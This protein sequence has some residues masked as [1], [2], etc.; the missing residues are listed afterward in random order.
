MLRRGARAFTLLEMLVV[1]AIMMVLM[2]LLFPVAMAAYESANRTACMSN[3]QLIS[4][5]V[6]MYRQDYLVY[7]A[8]PN[9]IGLH[10]IPQGGVTGLA[11]ASADMVP[12]NFWCNRDAYPEQLPP[13]LYSKVGADGRM[14][15]DDATRAANGLERDVT[16]STYQAFYNYY[17]YVTDNDGLPF[18]VT[19]LEAFRYFFGDPSEVSIG[20]ADPDWDLDLVV[21]KPKKGDIPEFVPRGLTQAL[22]NTWAP[23]ETIITYC[24]HHPSG[25]P[26]VLPAVNILGE[27]ELLRPIRPT[28][29]VTL[30]A[31]ADPQT[32]SSYTSVNESSAVLRKPVISVGGNDVYYTRWKPPI[33][34]RINRG[35]YRVRRDNGVF[36]V[37]ED[38]KYISD[39]PR[40]PLNM[41]V[42]ETYY[43]RFVA[44]PGANG[45]LY[46]SSNFY[47]WYDTGISLN[48]GDMVMVVATAKWNFQNR[49][50]NYW[51][52]T[53][54]GWANASTEY[55]PY[56]DDTNHLWFT[57][58]GNPVELSYTDMRPE[59][60]LPNHP[61]CLLVGFVGDPITDFTGGAV[62]DDGNPATNTPSPRL[63]N[64]FPIGSRGSFLAARAGTLKVSSNDI[65]GASANDDNDGWCELWVAVYRHNSK[66]L[67][68]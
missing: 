38:S 30:P 21:R 61:H 23:K 9:Y 26:S 50:K 4:Q 40:A 65:R 32:S 7:P 55:E 12:R 62:D 34:W 44:K 42:V 56:F 51:L 31:T 6:E 28:A 19:T 18:P 29:P 16:N 24:P 20:M 66:V 68:Q 60:L 5:R 49:N 36:Q 1:V 53:S 37:V 41:P 39:A 64:Y 43:R 27:A 58:E 33:D 22:W 46:D 25:K 13:A 57:A 11:L 10:G 63:K 35:A 17:G 59:L 15:P 67:P 48:Q 47:P 54:G 2:A 3:L 52:G 8:M 45:P 14:H